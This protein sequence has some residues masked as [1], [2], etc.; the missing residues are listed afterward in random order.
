[1]ALQE[2][3]EI[4]SLCFV[5]VCMLY[6]LSLGGRMIN[7]VYIFMIFFCHHENRLNPENGGSGHPGSQRIQALLLV[8]IQV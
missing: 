3:L 8:I 1:M 2:T 7:N 4:F 5:Y 6:D